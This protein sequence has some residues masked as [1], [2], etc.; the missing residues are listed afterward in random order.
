MPQCTVYHLP[1]QISKAILYSY[2]AIYIY[3]YICIQRKM[4]LLKDRVGLDS[5]NVKY[6]LLKQNPLNI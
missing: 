6:S 1:T 5:V 4:N 2:G 3:I